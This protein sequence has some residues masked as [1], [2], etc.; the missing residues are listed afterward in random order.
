M[1]WTVR[2]IAKWGITGKQQRPRTGPNRC[3]ASRNIQNSGISNAKNTFLRICIFR[4]CGCGYNRVQGLVATRAYHCVEWQATVMAYKEYYEGF[5]ML[6]L[7]H[8]KQTNPYKMDS[9][10]LSAAAACWLLGRGSRAIW[11]CF[12]NSLTCQWLLHLS[13]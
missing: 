4:C 10:K 12:R 5:Y 7:S 8:Y 3:P 1:T 9:K 6:L 2:K 11:E 13:T